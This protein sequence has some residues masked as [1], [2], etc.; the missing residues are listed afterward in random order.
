MKLA[1]ISLLIFLATPAFSGVSDPYANWIPKGWDIIALETGDLNRDGIDDAV[2]VV[3]EANPA[4]LKRNRESPGADILN[5]NP[6]RLIILFNTSGG[7]KEI[8]SRD[9]LLPSENEENNPCLADPLDGK[10]VS[11]NR[12][13]L[14]I[15]LQT[16]LSCGSYG[17]TNEKFTFRLEDTRFRLIGYDYSEFSRSSGEQ[18]EFS[19]NYLTGK[20]KMTEGLNVFKDSKPKVSWKNLPPKRNFYLDEMPLVCAAT[21]PAHKD[22]WCQ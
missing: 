7:F 3:E 22:N 12:G 1:I 8:L 15:E 17:V 16:W 21:N 4:N 5:L 10:G 9:G 18:S 6:R 14:V 2:L 11:I 20:I 19:I 13:N